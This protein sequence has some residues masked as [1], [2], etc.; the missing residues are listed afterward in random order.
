MK[1]LWEHDHPYYC[2]EGCYYRSGPDVHDQ[3]PSWSSFMESW[4]DSDENYNMLMRWDWCVGEEHGIGKDQ[5]EL[6]LYFFQQ[7]HAKPH[8]VYVAVTPADEDAVRA[9]LAT[10][11]EHTKRLW[12]PLSDVAT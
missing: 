2:T 5:H 7:R 10:R 6:R 11:W 1:H 12:A 4:G 8:S 3:E 9:W